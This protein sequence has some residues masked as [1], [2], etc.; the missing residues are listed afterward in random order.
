MKRLLLTALVLG[1]GAAPARALDL[2]YLDKATNT[3]LIESFI[4]QVGQR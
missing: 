1:L 2:K 3:A 4:A